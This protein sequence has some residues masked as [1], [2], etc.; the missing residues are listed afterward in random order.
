VAAPAA[1]PK[2]A[3]GRAGAATAG[4]EAAREEFE[5]LHPRAAKGRTGG[6][7]WIK[8]GQG[9]EGEP[10]QRVRQ[11]QNRLGSLG[12]KVES[13]GRFGPITEQ[14]VRAF[15]QRNGLKADGVVGG[16]TKASLRG[17]EPLD[18]K[19]AAPNASAGKGYGAKYEGDSA[20]ARQARGDQNEALA[21][22]RDIG[23]KTKAEKK[24][25]SDRK[26]ERRRSRSR[27]DDDDEGDVEDTGEVI[28]GGDASDKSSRR[29]GRDGGTIA[30]G[31]G[32][33]RQRGD[34]RVGEL[35]QM[36]DDIGMDL[37]AGGTDG[38]FGPDT[39]RA[40]LRFQRK[41]GLKA[42]GIFG[43]KTRTALNTVQKLMNARERQSP[44]SSLRE[45][46]A[47]D[48][49][50]VAAM[51]EADT[52]H[53][54]PPGDS[55][56]EGMKRCPSC[57]WRNAKGKTKCAKCGASLAKKGD[58]KL[59]EDAWGGKPGTNWKQVGAHAKKK[60]SASAPS[61]PRRSAPS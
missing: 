7:S 4:D 12:Y 29:R 28:D 54:G 10:D 15:Q 47:N 36:L 8:K 44:G 49:A 25:A 3:K 39:R 17:A 33:D 41:Y 23:T 48:R 61:A 45:H 50:V 35:Q 16:A 34:K 52:K 51:L 38:K 37:G 56:G 11:L 24:A 55:K 21:G 59:S 32:M 19:A 14:A 58:A 6:G 53:D 22:Q 27:S 30:L 43:K 5:R 1:P 46:L 26:R 2:K 60:L 13:D 31:L 18:T 40:L 9:M 20:E 57:D 42:D